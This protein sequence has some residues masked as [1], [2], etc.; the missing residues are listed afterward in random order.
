VPRYSRPT[1]P[2]LPVNVRQA[3]EAIRT[4]V[5]IALI[6]FYGDHPG[7]GQAAA[8]EA[9]GHP[10]RTISTSTR[11]LVELG[12]LLEEPTRGPGPTKGYTVNEPR[13][14]E[15]VDALDWELRG[16][17]RNSPNDPML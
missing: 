4:E 6:A 1:R 5:R 7:A 9:L 15:L 14:D 8:A 16:R 17:R 13:L 3:A 12:V 10:Q 11:G 2:P